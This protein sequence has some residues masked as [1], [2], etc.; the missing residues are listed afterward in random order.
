MWITYAWNKRI[1]LL[2]LY[3]SFFSPFH[4]HFVFVSS[5]WMCFSAT[6]NT[7]RRKWWY[8][9][10][11]RWANGYDMNYCVHYKYK[12]LKMATL[13]RTKFHNANHSRPMFMGSL[14]SHCLKCAKSRAYIYFEW[15]NIKWIRIHYITV[16]ECEWERNGQHLMLN[17]STSSHSCP[18]QSQWLS[19]MLSTFF[20]LTEKYECWHE[21]KIGLI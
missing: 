20:F 14:S 8:C 6:T 19:R 12:T 16:G 13:I 5:F 3:S 7:Y 4:S 10:R 21:N 17:F 1:S 9:K 2:S 18:T 15:P 11:Y